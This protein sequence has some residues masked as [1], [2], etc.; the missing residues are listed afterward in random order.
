MPTLPEVIE[1]NFT[2][3]E[4]IEQHSADP[5]CAKCHAKIDPFGFALEQFDTVGRRRSEPADTTAILKKGM[6][7]EGLAGLRNYLVED[8]RDVFVRQFCRKLLGYALGRA[9]NPN[10]AIY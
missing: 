4:L 9:A 3:R 6:T 7:L 10:P 8:Q 1:G 5:D 2:A